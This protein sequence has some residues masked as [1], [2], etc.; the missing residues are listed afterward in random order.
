LFVAFNAIAKWLKIIDI[1][2]E[3]YLWQMQYN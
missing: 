3:R 2:F 1:V